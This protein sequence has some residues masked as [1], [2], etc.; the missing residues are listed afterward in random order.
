MSF[1]YAL[2][3]ILKAIKTE[4]NLRFH[5]VIANLI[6]IFAR[7]YGLDRTQWAILLVTAFLV[8]SLELINTAVE[9]A[10]DTATYEILPSAKL[11]KDA[12]A[13][14]V[15]VMAVASLLVGVCLFGDFNRILDTLAVI[16][17]D[18][19]NLA[20]CL[21]VGIADMLFLFLVREKPLKF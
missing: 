3:G 19:W 17:T 4:R 13:G 12:S 6:C 14:A 18:I 21:A 9:K 15:L 1:V 20:W 7:F 8:I 10:V 16:F 5:I 2:S 11:A